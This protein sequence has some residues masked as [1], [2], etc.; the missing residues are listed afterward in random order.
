MPCSQQKM[1]F[2]WAWATMT[3]VAKTIEL[4]IVTTKGVLLATFQR[5]FFFNIFGQENR[6]LPYGQ[7][8]L[9]TIS[10]GLKREEV[11]SNVGNTVE[12]FH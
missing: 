10:T 5:G 12:T 4:L 8:R 3:K 7:D 6:C 11:I 9:T 2:C 1:V